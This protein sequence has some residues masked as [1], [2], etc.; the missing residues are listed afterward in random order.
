MAVRWSGRRVSSGSADW[1]YPSGE[2]WHISA[3]THRATIVSVGGGVREYEYAGIP[4]IAS[5]PTTALAPAGA[6]QILAPWP[7]RLDGGH[8]LYNGQSY[9]LPISE[10]ERGNAIHGLVRWLPWHLLERRDDE[11]IVGCELAPQP[12]YPWALQLTTRWTV[13][14]A[15]LR[16][17]HTV[18]NLSTQ[19]CPF[20][21]GAH[22]YVSIPGTPLRDLT[23]QV[24]AAIRL[25][26]DQR[27]L[28]NGE[29]PVRDTSYD[30]LT[31]RVIG[32]ID[33]DDTFT[34]LLNGADGTTRTRLS[35]VD[36]SRG[37]EIWQDSQFNWL[38]LYNGPGP[39]GNPGE[40][41]AIEPMTCPP[42]AL[43]TGEDLIHLH[44]G[45]PWTASWG[46]SP[47]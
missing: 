15:G 40:A 42:N 10:I 24:P 3:G 26:T 21:L 46:L 27:M 9:Q 13:S 39:T 5:Y 37:V 12:G 19:Q 34:G 20:G 14:S 8:Y 32:S 35:T 23:L 25:L 45:E 43:R 7:N 4:V 22:P 30:F 16:A 31:P 11:L 38:Q 18:T 17:T 33:F 41:L 28:P 2:Q 1:P 36:G 47:L 6:G 44:P 29:E